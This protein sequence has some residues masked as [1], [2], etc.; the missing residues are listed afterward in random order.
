MVK[1]ILFSMVAYGAT[2]IMIFGSIF[3]GWRNFFG[4]NSD[5]PKFFGKLF[6]C[7]MCLPF[8][9][10]VIL[11]IFMFS[12]TIEFLNDFYSILKFYLSL[13]FDGCLGSGSVWLI[14]TLQEKLEK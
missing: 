12:P 11:S 4:V 5:E 10:G 7:F 2:N 6:G 14:H 1:L 8:W 3:N 13:F 9:W